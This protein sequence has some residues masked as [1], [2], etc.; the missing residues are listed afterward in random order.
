[1]LSPT[2]ILLSSTADVSL[3]NKHAPQ[4][5]GHGGF[6]KKKSLTAGLAKDAEEQKSFAAEAAKVAEEQK[7]FIAEAAMAAKKQQSFTAKNAE[8]AKDYRIG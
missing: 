2:A 7:S 1:M 4:A 8:D 5:A 3:N 6:S